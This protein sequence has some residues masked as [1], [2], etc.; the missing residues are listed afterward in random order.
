[1]TLALICK[2]SKKAELAPNAERALP[3]QKR[4]KRASI[5][6]ADMPRCHDAFRP[7][8]SMTPRKILTRFQTRN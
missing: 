8:V 5:A 6:R 1:M 3:F 7:S 2:I 4:V